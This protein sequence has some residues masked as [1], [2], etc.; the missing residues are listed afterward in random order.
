[1]NQDKRMEY[2]NRIM[3]VWGEFPDDV[4]LCTLIHRAVC[5]NPLWRPFTDEV[6]IEMLE[7]LRSEVLYDQVRTKRNT[8][9][10]TVWASRARGE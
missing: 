6:L 8:I 3:A 4:E 2:L 7:Q 9:P 10:G 5:L 1:M